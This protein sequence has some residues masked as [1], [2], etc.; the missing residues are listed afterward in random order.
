M[1]SVRDSDELSPL[2]NT[3]D[4]AD[5]FA[6]LVATVFTLDRIGD[7]PPGHYGLADGATAVLP[8]TP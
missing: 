3:V 7:L 2:Y 8:E 1:A 5:W 4:D 6:G